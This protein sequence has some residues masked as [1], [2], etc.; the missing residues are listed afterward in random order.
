MAITIWKNVK[1]IDILP[2]VFGTVAIVAVAAE[3]RH[4]IGPAGLGLLTALGCALTCM[5]LGLISAAISKAKPPLAQFIL[6]T[7]FG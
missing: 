2:S 4:I 3:M 1:L 5:T 7:S 6:L